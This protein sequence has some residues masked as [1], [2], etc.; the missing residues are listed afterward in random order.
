MAPL[1][2]VFQPNEIELMRSALDEPAIILP[3]AGKTPP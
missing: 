2:P 3:K 1:G